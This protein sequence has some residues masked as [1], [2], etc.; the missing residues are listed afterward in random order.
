MNIGEYMDK[1]V[2]CELKGKY[3]LHWNYRGLSKLPVEI[4]Y[5]GGHVQEMYLKCNDLKQLPVWLDKLE[6]LRHLYLHGN[7]ISELPKSIGGMLSLTTLDL[8][9]NCLCDLT[10]SIGDLKHLK[11]LNLQYNY[12]KKIPKEIRK[13]RSLLLLNL[14]GN[15]LHEICDEVCSLNSLR[16]LILD[17]NKITALPNNIVYMPNLSYLSLDGNQ[18]KYLPMVKFLNKPML[19]IANNKYLNYVSYDLGCSMTSHSTMLVNCDLWHFNCAGCFKENLDIS[20]GNTLEI[21]SFNTRIALPPMLK[22]VYDENTKFIPSLYELA[23]RIGYSLYFCIHDLRECLCT[24]DIENIPS[25]LAT[26]FSSGPVA[27]CQYCSGPIFTEAV[28]WVF[29]RYLLHIKPEWPEFF[30][31]VMCFCTQNC[32]LKFIDNEI[33][34]KEYNERMNVELIKWSIG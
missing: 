34:I 16:E 14:K 6:S 26:M 12:I 3:T 22:K 15:Q 7:R 29:P 17:E 2:I 24:E 18:L 20:C 30:L 27:S 33:F 32:S 23:L 21:P 25:E 9:N 4:L 19:S 10:P 13:L 5:H 11:V 28:L 1:G 31:A 8:Q